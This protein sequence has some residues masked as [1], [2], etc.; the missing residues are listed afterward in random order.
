[1][2]KLPFIFTLP[3]QHGPTKLCAGWE[4]LL[5][6]IVACV[7]YYQK[8]NI[9]Q[10]L[11]FKIIAKASK[12]LFLVL[13]D[14]CYTS[15]RNQG[16]DSARVGGQD[17]KIPPARALRKKNHTP[18]PPYIPKYGQSQRAYK[19]A[20]RKT[21]RV[22]AFFIKKVIPSFASCAINSFWTKQSHFSR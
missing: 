5:K 14:T 18:F 7:P 8:R 10:Y 11:T 12:N 20:F 16:Q 2:A 13:T 1:M 15:S 19:L 21:D 22:I 17:R 4:P 3:T 6:A 9:R